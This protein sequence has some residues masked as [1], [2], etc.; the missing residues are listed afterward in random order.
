MKVIILIILTASWGLERPKKILALWQGIKLIYEKYGSSAF[1]QTFI[2]GLPVAFV[3]LNIEHKTNNE[4]LMFFYS[5]E[6][7]CSKISVLS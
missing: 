6:V 2:C 4:T 1:H 7:A 3:T 5:K